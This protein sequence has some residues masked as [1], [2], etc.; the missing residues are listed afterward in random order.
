VGNKRRRGGAP[1]TL[2]EQV[3]CPTCGEARDDGSLIQWKGI[4]MCVRCSVEMLEE[5]LH[6]APADFRREARAMNDERRF[7]DRAADAEFRGEKMVRDW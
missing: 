3:R 1:C 7:A 5:E 4:E 2:L 6:G